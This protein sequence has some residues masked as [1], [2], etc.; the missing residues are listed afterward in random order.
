MA[1]AGIE[2]MARAKQTVLVSKAAAPTRAAAERI[3][4]RHADRVYTSR[5]TE[6]FW[7][8]RQ[9]PPNCFSGGFRQV[10]IRGGKVQILYG[11]LKKGAK[12]RK[13]CR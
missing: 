9:R 7:R 5:E 11:T 6:N 4:R 8:F 3:A 12:R 1:H 10:R 13:A 2:T